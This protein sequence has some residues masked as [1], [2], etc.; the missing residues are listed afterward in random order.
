MG[1]QFVFCGTWLHLAFNGILITP[2]LHEFCSDFSSDIIGHS[3]H[4]E[5]LGFATHYSNATDYSAYR[6]TA[7]DNSLYFNNRPDF[8]ATEN[9]SANSLKMN[10]PLQRR[11]LNELLNLVKTGIFRTSE[12]QLYSVSVSFTR[13]EGILRVLFSENTLRSA[14]KLFCSRKADMIAIFQILRI[15]FLGKLRS[16]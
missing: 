2:T 13:N 4:H 14:L 15:P 6:H 3:E 12:W 7:T 16:Q 5:T 10:T 11:A 8:Q 1:L 9:Y